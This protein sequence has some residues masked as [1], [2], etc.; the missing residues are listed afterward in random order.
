MHIGFILVVFF[1]EHLF[2]GSFLRQLYQ[3]E[4]FHRLSKTKAT[5][6]SKFVTKVK[7]AEQLEE[8]IVK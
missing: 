4:R 7:N 8:S 6:D 3:V 1:Q 2:K 5:P